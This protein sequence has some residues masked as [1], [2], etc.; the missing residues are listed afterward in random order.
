MTENKDNQF[1]Y[2]NFDVTKT[3]E[4]KENQVKIKSGRELIEKLKYYIDNP[5]FE[6]SKMLGGWCFWKSYSA[7]SD[8]VQSFIKNV[9]DNHKYVSI[10]IYSKYVDMIKVKKSSISPLQIQYVLRQMT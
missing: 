1:N 8:S 4:Y 6:G 3:T 5:F 7:E 9:N 2:D 10:E